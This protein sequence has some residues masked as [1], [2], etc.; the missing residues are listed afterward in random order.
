MQ[1]ERPVYH[2]TAR[3]KGGVSRD[4]WETPAEIFEP[5][6][7]E[8]GGF[9]LDVAATAENTKCP[10]FITKERDGLTQPW[11][12]HNWMNPP[13]SQAD[14]WIE[15]AYQECIT[16]RQ[17][18]VCLLAS[19]TDTLIWHNVVRLGEVRY[20]KG[21]LTFVGADSPAPFPSAVV[22]FAPGGKPA[23]YYWD[24]KKGVLSKA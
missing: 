18:T 6:S 13:Y 23:T 21:R 5:L 1:A 19:R 22:I 8:F 7:E 14:K 24:W 12:G 15:K 11:S 9:Y 4:D 10:Y 2:R 16:D 20:L 3:E 17:T